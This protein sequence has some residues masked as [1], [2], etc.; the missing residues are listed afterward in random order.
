VL[1]VIGLNVASDQTSQHAPAVTPALIDDRS[2]RANLRSVL[3]RV[4]AKLIGPCVR[5]VGKRYER[6]FGIL[7]Y[8]RVVPITSS[9]PT[10]TWNVPSDILRAQLSGLLRQGFQPWR[11]SALLDAHLAGRPI[12]RQAF[13]VT[14]DD[15]YANVLTQALPVLHELSI[16]ATVFLATAYLDRDEPFP[17]D[18][19]SRAEALAAPGDHWRP[20]TTGECRTLLAGGLIDL[21]THTHTHAD[22]RNRP[23]ALFQ[24]LE[25][26]TALLRS[27]F[28]VGAAM[29]AF[30]YGVCRLGFA[31]GALSEAARRAGVRCALTTESDLI[32][33]GDDPFTWGRFNVKH[34][35]CANS[36]GGR[37]SGWYQFIRDGWRSVKS[38]RLRRAA[39]LA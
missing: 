7:N 31:G 34:E 2:A 8:H 28:G 18:D 37:L 15:G 17:F 20:L 16:P 24:E 23:D 27:R 33:P 3:P 36:L 4:A 35:D 13:A 21:G 12:P 25:I 6:A 26:S 10:P 29:F 39:T 32:R 1:K 14:F 30:P 22:F 5:L 38:Y 9:A 11:L 19:W